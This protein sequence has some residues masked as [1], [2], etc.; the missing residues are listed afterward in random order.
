[1][2]CAHIHSTVRV[3]VLNALKLVDSSALGTHTPAVEI[4]CAQ[5]LQEE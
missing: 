4:T 3:F 1:M 5:S 2:C